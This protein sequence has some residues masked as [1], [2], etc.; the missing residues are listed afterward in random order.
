MKKNKTNRVII[1]SS[2]F[3]ILIVSLII[4]ILNYTKDSSS[5]SIIEKNWINK[6][7][8]NV[9]D[10]S[11]Y[12]DVP[13]YGYNGE[14]I[15]FSFLED[16]SKDYGIS[17]NRVSYFSDNNSNLKD[18]AFRILNYNDELS[19]N[20]I[21]MYEDEYVI[22][23]K[24]DKLLDD[25]RD[26]DSAKLGVF[27]N[28]I[29]S[30]S[31]YLYG[32]NNISYVPYDNIDDLINAIVDGN[33]EYIALPNVMYMDDIL[34]NDLNIVYHISELKKQ[35]VLTVNNNSTLLSI[36]KKYNNIYKDNDR[37][38]IINTKD[39]ITISF[40]GDISLADNFDIMPYYD[41]RNEGVY[42][43]LSKEVVDIMTTSD[44]MVANNE[45][46]ISKRG[47]PL[48]KTYT[49]R[50]DPKRINIYKEMGIDM[51]SLA[52]NHIYDYG[53]EAFIDT[54]N[55]L[56]EEGISYSGA[57]ININEA[58]KA[59]YFIV[60]GYKIAFISST[61]AE[62]NIIT[63]G[64][65][66]TE[67][68]TFRC[69]DPNPLIET[70][71]EEKEKSDYVILLIHWGKEDSHEI[72]EVLYETGKK[73]IDAGA[74][75]IVGSHA[76]LLQGMEFYNNKLI[77]YNLGDFIFNRETKDTGILK[78]TINN[79][80]N[81]QYNFVPCKQENY[82]TS[83]LSDKEKLRVLENMTNYSVN[84]LFD[85]NGNILNKN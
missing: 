46:T 34:A 31:Y 53:E 80:G 75:L 58:K 13:I 24:E 70:I 11:T 10:I 77:A 62:K 25:I 68:G 40:V 60:N 54:L 49:F 44:I 2:I 74:D 81:M 82:K 51:V 73:Y 15:I 7:K 3:I 69:Y 26:I 23:S 28:D 19:D 43:I 79:E 1:L 52:N 78:L 38:K 61:R 55:Y 39:N 33:V 5:F 84:I 14:G 36:M 6:N 18:S 56:K 41:K 59:S 64:A 4:F 27:N 16:F 32:A 20:D 35:Y 17:F 37:V 45:F 9:I 67:S 29:S 22:V 50:A 85:E 71:K 57:G 66:E 65:T 83:L 76:H 30:V 42:G 72:E 47:T 48:N 63:P 8:N 12:N 21:L